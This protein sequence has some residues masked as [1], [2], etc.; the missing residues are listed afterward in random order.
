M[1]GSR[2]RELSDE[3]SVFCSPFA[4]FRKDSGR[5]PVPLS[6]GG[7]GGV[8]A[9]AAEEYRVLKEEEARIAKKNR[10]AFGARR[11]NG[12]SRRR[13]FSVVTDNCYCCVAHFFWSRA[14]KT[15]SRLVYRSWGAVAPDACAAANTRNTKVY[16]ALPEPTNTPIPLSIKACTLGVRVL[17]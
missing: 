1:I 13:A 3:K 4:K 17:G 12:Q 9:T 6:Q 11:P 5:Q 8:P 14:L 7:G 2:D 16:A 10:N 15:R